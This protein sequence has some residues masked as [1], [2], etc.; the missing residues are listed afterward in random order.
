MFQVGQ[1]VIEKTAL[2]YDDITQSRYGTVIEVVENENDWPICVVLHD[3]PLRSIWRASR[4]YA[5]YYTLWY[6]QPQP[7]PEP[8]TPAAP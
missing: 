8:D 5:D 3:E 4:A 2:L 6:D 7:I 1:R